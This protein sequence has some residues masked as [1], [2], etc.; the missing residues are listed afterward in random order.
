MVRR[1][2]VQHV[3]VVVVIREESFT[4]LLETQSMV[5]I[6]IVALEEK[7]DL[8]SSR[9][10]SNSCESFSHIGLRNVTVTAVIENHKAVV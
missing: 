5:L 8:I 3:A 1:S 2:P 10:D 4:K 9:V 6:L 7:P